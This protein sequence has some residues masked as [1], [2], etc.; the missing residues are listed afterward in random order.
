[1]T[2]FT[3]TPLSLYDLFEINMIR[4]FNCHVIIFYRTT[5]PMSLLVGYPIPP[6]GL[7]Y[8]LRRT[9]PSW[10]DYSNPPPQGLTPSPGR[11]TISSLKTPS[12]PKDDGIQSARRWYLSYWNV[13][14]FNMYSY[15]SVR[16]LNTNVVIYIQMPP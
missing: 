13:V 9:T 7:P 3:S 5:G 2:G 10:K 15:S 12:L 11:T 14:L 6:E 16:H 8:P 1:M 4:N